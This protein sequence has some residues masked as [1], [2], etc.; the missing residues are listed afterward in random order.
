MEG[1]KSGF[2]ILLIIV[3]VLTIVVAALAG[4]IL[5]FS[6]NNQKSSS[7]N[8]KTEDT[9]K[10]VN[11]SDLSTFELYESKSYFNL[12]STESDKASHVIQVNVELRYLTKVTG[13]SDVAKK[14]EANKGEI[15]ELVGSYFLNVTIDEVKSVE[16]KEKA[17]RDL[18]KMI[19][20]LL[21]ST[22]KEKKGDIVYTVVISDWF[23]Q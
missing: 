11:E 19:N 4:Y 2:M 8:V 9:T 20:D 23:F 10:V 14:L 22:E 15:Q 6:G 21:N 12:K 16:E 5:L 17:K 18:K 13:I 7:E 3:V 1:N